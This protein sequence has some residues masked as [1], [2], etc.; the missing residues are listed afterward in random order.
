[1]ADAWQNRIYCGDN[2]ERLAQLPSES[3]DLLYLDPPFFSNRDYEV[4]FGDEAEVR[5]F[6]DRWEGG[7]GHYVDWM[8]QRALQFQ[9]VLSQKGSLYVHCD[10]NASHYLKVMLD[11][12]FGMSN[13]RNEII[14]E[15][16][17]SKALMKRRLPTNH[18]VILAYQR[19]DQATWNLESTFQPYDE[20]ALDAKTADK[21]EK[22][23]ENGRRYQLTSLINPSHDR[24][25][26]TYEF[27]GVTRVWRWTRERMQEAHAA[28]LVVQTRPGAVPR[29][30]RYLDEQRGKPLG[31]VWTDIAPL[32]SRA[33]E[34]QG[35]PTQKPEALLARIIEQSTNRGDLVLDPFCGCGTTIAVADQLK[36]RWLG[37]DISGT[38]VRVM[39]RRLHRQGT[40]DFEV[41]GLP[42]NTDDLRALKP[43][44]F[45]NWIIDAVHGV[46]AP[47]RVGDIDGYSF[48]ERLP[49]QVKQSD[50][51][52][53]QVIDGFE[54]AVRREGK[55]KGFV[56][57]FSFTKGAH[58]E[59]A[60]AKQ[61]GL[62]IGLVTVASLLDNP[63]EE[64][65]R[66]GLPSMTAE[67]L[68]LARRAAKRGVQT[69][70]LPQI[71][72][73]ELVESD[74]A[75][76]LGRIEDCRYVLDERYGALP[77]LLPFERHL[78]WSRPRHLPDA[79]RLGILRVS[80]TTR[81]ELLDAAWGV[82]RG[83]V[84]P[85]LD[86][87][88]TLARRRGRSRGR[89]ALA[90]RRPFGQKS[91]SRFTPCGQKPSTGRSSQT[92][93]SGAWSV[94]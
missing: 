88:G 15:R 12:V 83:V 90:A 28:G 79:S 20:E 93:Q 39:R 41:V 22:R 49:I 78:D 73:K 14:W 19:S 47:R 16:T 10:Q 89:P 56:I 18:D 80:G 8:Q 43:F 54:T 53:R 94:A 51:I 25:N 50:R 6:E 45:Q 91:R 84:T 85:R 2:M 42:E 63:V 64:E 34:R 75:G 5:S 32:N 24:P 87:E 36:R 69:V 74:L 61:E 66:A 23:D 13:F 44:E 38:A 37:I 52:G 65:P 30:K 59:A 77:C 21:Y 67:L 7:I 68:E 3:V 40:F 27:L 17:P 11:R 26:L 31:D 81:R 82:G 57:A 58:E 71:T 46:H 33:R 48:F 60:R 9:R 86:S 76:D 70:T 29:Y 72:A 62:E 1:M 35:Y 4:I 92:E 55:H